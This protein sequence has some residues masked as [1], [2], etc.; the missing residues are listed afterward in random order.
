MTL[1]KYKLIKISL[2]YEDFVHCK[3][4]CA[5]KLSLCHNFIR[6]DISDCVSLSYLKLRLFDPTE[7]VV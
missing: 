6:I 2:N 1:L 7:L 3:K 5:K 4:E